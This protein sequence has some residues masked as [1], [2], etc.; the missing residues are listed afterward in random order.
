[1]KTSFFVN[2]SLSFQAEPTKEP[3]RRGQKSRLG[4]FKIVKQ[5]AKQSWW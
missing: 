2:L 3:M 5:K 4:K 1:M